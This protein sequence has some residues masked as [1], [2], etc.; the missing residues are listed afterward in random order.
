MRT[1]PLSS[2]HRLPYPPTPPGGFRGTGTWYFQEQQ[3]R[4]DRMG[5]GGRFLAI[6]YRSKSCLYNFYSFE[7][8]LLCLHSRLGK[9][10]P[11]LSKTE[12]HT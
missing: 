11:G 4:E 5:G 12:R 2:D 1:G 10:V 7:R 3:Q 9:S 6:G 8:N